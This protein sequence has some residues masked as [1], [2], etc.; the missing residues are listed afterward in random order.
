MENGKR[1]LGR[2]EWEVENV[3]WNEK[4]ENGVTREFM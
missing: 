2:E 1:R 3:K 4:W